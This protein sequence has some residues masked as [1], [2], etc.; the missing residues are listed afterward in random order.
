MKCSESYIFLQ[1]EFQIRLLSFKSKIE[2]KRYL[3]KRSFIDQERHLALKILT[4]EMTHAGRER[5]NT[6]TKKYQDKF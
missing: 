1:M 5:K 4:S 3:Q 2:N 6:P